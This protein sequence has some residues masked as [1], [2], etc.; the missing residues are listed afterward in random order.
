VPPL[1][2]IP[3]LSEAREMLLA[4]VIS[5]SSGEPGFVS[6]MAGSVTGD[7]DRGRVWY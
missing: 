7:E 2:F 3:S 1:R 4:V 5:V 6:D